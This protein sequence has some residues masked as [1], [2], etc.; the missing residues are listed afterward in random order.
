MS[1]INSHINQEKLFEEVSDLIE[2]TQ[3]ETLRKVSQTGVLLYWHIGH[4]IDREILKLN[5]AEYGKD[6]IS[7]LAQNLQ[8]KFGQ[9]FGERIIYRCI[10]FTKFFQEEDIVN[11]LSG[12]LKWSH[13]VTLLNIDD[14]LK[15]N[16][17]AEMCRVERWSVRALKDKMSGML[18][19]RTALAKKPE[20]VIR[21]EILKL[22]QSNIL[23]PDFIM[24][25]PVILQFLSSQDIETEEA[26]EQAIIRD[27]EHFLLSMGAGFTFQERQKTIEVDGEHFKIDLLMY[28]RRLKSMVVIELKMGKF[29]PQDKGQIE[30]YLRWLEKNE[31]QPGENPPIGIILC[32]DKSHERVEL[33]ALDQSGIHVS[34]FITELPP[35]EVFEDRLHL[36]I[37]KARDRYEQ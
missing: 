34:Q 31:M 26:F 24:Q 3:R 13:F 21:K 36:A 9:G 14:E 8:I 20:E 6:I 5:R 7:Q 1:N 37:K 23:K 19:E 27:I 33:L 29:K 10:Q 30:L 4:R 11:A 18:Y 17:Y 25:D 12:H 28:N 16:F 35:K 2:T 32:S 15:R 22:R